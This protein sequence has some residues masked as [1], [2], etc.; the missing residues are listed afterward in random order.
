MT[1]T[2]SG[3]TRVGWI[4]ALKGIGILTVAAGHIFPH[5]VAKYLYIF[6]MPL[7]FFIGGFLFKPSENSGEF[8]TKKAF[9][10]LV[11]YVVFLCLIYVPCEISEYL[12]N[13]ESLKEA[14]AR[15]VLGGRYLIGWCA[16]FWY[17]T[18]FFLVQQIMNYLVNNVKRTFIAWLMFVCLLISYALN[19][20]LPAFWLPWNADVVFAAIPIFYIGY[21]YKSCQSEMAKFKWIWILMMAGAFVLTYYYPENIYEMKSGRY[22]IPF[23]TL[24]SAL[25]IIFGLIEVAKLTEHSVFVSK[26]LSELGKASMIVMYLHQPVQ[27]IMLEHLSITSPVL[28]FLVAIMVSMGGYYLLNNMEMGRALF[29]GSIADFKKVF[30]RNKLATV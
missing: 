3:P 18:C 20:W 7:F 29:L 22:G 8:F 21:L 30:G 25:M 23:V 17:I 4:D 9:H 24:L 5:P 13:K 1:S 10:L 6:H 27:L 28:R 2:T 15:P 19:R 11:P 26:P 14:F 12:D 16:V